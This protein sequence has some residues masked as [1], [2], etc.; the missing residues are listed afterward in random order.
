MACH[1]QYFCCVNIQYLWRLFAINIKF[2]S[3]CCADKA[4]RAKFI[5]YFCVCSGSQILLTISFAFIQLILLLRGLLRDECVRACGRRENESEASHL[6][7]SSHLLNLKICLLFC[8]WLK[9]VTFRNFS[10]NF[11]HFPRRFSTDLLLLKLKMEME[12][13]RTT[14]KNR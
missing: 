9:R 5:F 1:K 10:L 14:N 12:I 13:R 7:T 11:Y 6:S 4:D 8:L 2:D 3:N